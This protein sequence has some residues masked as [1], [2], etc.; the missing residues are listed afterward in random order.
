MSKKRLG[1]IYRILHVFTHHPWLKL[2]SLVLA[3]ILWLYIREEM[4]LGQ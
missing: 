4:L 2:I 1:I 3:V